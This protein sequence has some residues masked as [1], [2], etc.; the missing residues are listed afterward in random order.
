MGFYVK[1][2]VHETHKTAINRL[3][4]LWF[5]FNEQDETIYCEAIFENEEFYLGPRL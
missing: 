5:S 1:N 4:S 3:D 2:R